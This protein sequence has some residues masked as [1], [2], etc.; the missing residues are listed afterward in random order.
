MV[1]FGALILTKT[2]ETTLAEVVEFAKRE[3]VQD[4][5]QLKEHHCKK[6][7]K[8]RGK[9]RATNR[10]D[11]TTWVRNLSSRILSDDETRV[12]QK[13]L[14]FA[15]TPKFIPK[16]DIISEIEDGIIGLSDANKELVRAE[17]V[18]TLASFRPTRSNISRGEREALKNLKNDESITIVK[19]DKGNCTVVLD[20][21]D[22]QSKMNDLLS[23]E[24]TYTSIRKNPVKKIERILNAKL[25]ALKRNGRFTE[26]QYFKLRSTDGIIPR[27]YG[28]I[29]IHKNDLPLRPIVSMI[30]SPLYEVSKYLATVIAPSVGTTCFSVK[31][32]F[33]FVNFLES[34]K[35]SSEDIMVSFDVVALF[36]SVPIELAIKVL[37]ERLNDDS[38]LSDRTSLHVDELIDLL[39]ICL[40]STDFVFRGEYFHQRFG[41][42]MGNPVSAIV[43]NLVMEDIERRIFSISNT[44]RFW[45]RFVDDVWAVLP[46]EKVSSF[47][48][49]ANS[50]ETSINFTC[51]LE[52]DNAIPF[53]DVVVTRRDDCSFSTKVYRKPSHTNRYL[54]FRSN[55]PLQHKFSVVRS[56]HERAMS[57]ST[58]DDDQSSEM[59]YIKDIL[60]SNNYPVSMLN[61]LY[62]QKS[63]D[64]NKCSK[65]AIL[66][67]IKGCSERISRY[68]RR[69]DIRTFYRPINKIVNMLGLPKDPVNSLDK[70]GVVYEINCN[71]CEKKSILD[72]LRTALPHA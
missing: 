8:L 33:Q 16:L 7:V 62:L 10:V 15:V 18:K 6:L 70:C 36:T 1:R 3:A 46:R 38:N 40:R 14:N 59:H 5:K 51:E 61:R 19:A 68:L 32:T 43:A 52:K 20:T 11:T 69:F 25:L 26:A 35:C 65:S 63:N 55:H 17:V 48:N 47:L 12:L 71:D 4:V 9:G 60:T 34:C 22:Y 23:D 66:P 58:F 31:N 53:L 44:I 28:L 64:L 37:T 41:C 27:I 2:S 67:Y 72:K 29:K 42:A 45:K 39:E 57:F 24:D 56:L 21:T 49:Y 54:D 13:G 50:L 30:G